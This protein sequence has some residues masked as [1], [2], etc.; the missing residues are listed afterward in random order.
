MKPQVVRIL[1][2]AIVGPLMMWGGLK[3]AQQGS[4]ALGGALVLLGAATIGY[5]ARNYLL[6]RRRTA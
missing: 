2:V 1:D 3:N 6:E 4:V 5:N